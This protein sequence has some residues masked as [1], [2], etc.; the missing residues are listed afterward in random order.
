MCIYFTICQLI[1]YIV[2]ATHA[3]SSPLH[4]SCRTRQRRTS[5]TLGLWCTLPTVCSPGHRPPGSQR[6][7]GP[8]RHCRFR[9]A[10]IWIGDGLKSCQAILWIYKCTEKYRLITV[11]NHT[12]QHQLFCNT[13]KYGLNLCKWQSLLYNTYNIIS[14]S[15]IYLHIII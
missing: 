6:E 9:G 3:W 7:R 4:C 1:C 2:S 10:S 8:G 13:Y 5:H 11:A 15:Q 12:P 14:H